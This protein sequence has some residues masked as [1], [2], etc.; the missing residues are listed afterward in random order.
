MTNE[1]I[2]GSIYMTAGLLVA[3]SLGFVYHVLAARL[4]GTN[5]YGILSFIFFMIM[6]V[7]STVGYGLMQTISKQISENN[8]VP[9]I[10]L[11]LVIAGITGIILLVIGKFANW[12]G[13]TPIYIIFVIS[14]IVFILLN[15]LQGILQGYRRMDL[16]AIVTVA[17]N[18]FKVIFLVI[19]VYLLNM[20]T[21]GGVATLLFSYVIISVILFL[22]VYLN[23]LINLKYS[24][25]ILNVLKSFLFIVSTR[26]FLCILLFFPPV[27]LKIVGG[28]YDDVA[29]FTAAFS[30]SKYVIYFFQGILISFFPNFVLV[31][32]SD[33]KLEQKYAQYGLSFAM[34]AG[35]VLVAFSYFFG[36]DA[37]EIIYGSEFI[38]PDIDTFTIFSSVGIFM[39]SMLL[40]DI[41][42]AKSNYKKLLSVW[43]ISSLG[44]L[45]ALYLFDSPLHKVEYGI[46]IY[47]IFS[48][49]L[50]LLSYLKD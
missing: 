21:F 18:V 46:L 42:I 26:L 38:L 37:V 12:I 11:S 6:V 39:I 41:Y 50:L 45:F 20:G 3:G 28:S 25:N 16:I 27:L 14:A 31:V 2:R 8:E 15:V 35:L 19:L 17:I 22:F 36:V 29:K 10:Y 49:V 48:M 40:N 7:G 13:Y 32:K 33:S 1:F 43:I 44:L 9:A 47:S 5:G 34:L 30:V 24:G 23:R 4:L